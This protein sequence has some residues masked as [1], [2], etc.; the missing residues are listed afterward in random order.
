MKTLEDICNRFKRGQKLY[1]KW[2][3]TGLLKKLDDLDAWEMS[4]RSE[5]L[6]ADLMRREADF[7]GEPQNE[8]KR[9][10]SDI[11]FLILRRLFNSNPKRS[12]RIYNGAL[13]VV[14]D[15]RKSFWKHIFDISEDLDRIFGMS[16]NCLDGEIEYTKIAT[17]QILEVKL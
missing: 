10:L 7:V 9:R 6:A 1:D 5:D 3:Q 8:K 2:E 15:G 14:E 4:C 11:L 12:I 16:Y 13:Y 17:D